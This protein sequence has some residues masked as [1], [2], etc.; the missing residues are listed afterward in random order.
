MPLFLS[1][2]ASISLRV[3]VVVLVRVSVTV[4]ILRAEVAQRCC[5]TLTTVLSRRR[6]RDGRPAGPFGLVSK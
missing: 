3:S 6:C 4:L 5:V 2:L 1:V